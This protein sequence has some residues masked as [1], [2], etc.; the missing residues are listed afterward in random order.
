MFAEA[1]LGI[2]ANLAGNSSDPLTCTM[3]GATCTR[4][5]LARVFPGG[6]NRILEL[7]FYDP[8]DLVVCQS[9]DPVEGC[10][11]PPMDGSAAGQLTIAPPA[12]ATDALGLPL[13]SWGC[14]YQFEGGPTFN[15][16]TCTIGGLDMNQNGRLLEVEIA[17]P[18]DFQCD[19]NSPGGCW[20]RAV[21]E[22]PE[23]VADPETP[24][25][26]PRDNTTW[27]ATLLGDPVR[28]VE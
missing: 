7:A 24:N 2:Y 18:A 16:A 1:K 20:V 10:D 23:T 28:L 19:Y 17:L 9:I 26:L 22:F 12:E 25:V 5:Y 4:F 14:T 27:S 13:T 6:A 3:G 21:F 8:G 11:Y 15:P